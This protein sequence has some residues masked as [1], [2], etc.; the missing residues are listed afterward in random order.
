LRVS[1]TPTRARLARTTRIYAG[2]RR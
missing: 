1:K 2:A